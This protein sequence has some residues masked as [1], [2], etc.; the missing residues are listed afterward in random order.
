M[1]I[2]L[3][4]A[5]VAKTPYPVYPLGISMIAA[6]LRNDGHDVVMFDFLQHDMS[7]ATLTAAIRETSPEL[8]GISLRNIDNVNLLNEQRYVDAV[9]NIVAAARKETDARIIIGGSGFSVMPGPILEEVG[10]D[11]G[12]VGEGERLICDFARDAAQGVYPEERILNAAPDLTGEDIPS[13]YYDPAILEFYLQAGNMAGVQTKR[14]CPH[15]CA[16]CTYPVLEGHAIRPRSPARVADD[17]ESLVN[18]LNTGYIFFTDSVFNDDA[19]HFRAIVEEMARRGIDTPWTA[20]FKPTGLDDDIVAAMKK[21]GLNAAEIGSDAPCDTTLRGLRKDFLF[22][23]IVA[24]NDL[25]RKHGIATAHYFMFGCPGETRDTVFESIENIKKLEK[26]AVFIFM[27]VRILPG[28]PLADVAIE[29]GVIETG[30]DLLEPVYYISPDIDRDWL[31][32]TL[33]DA[34]AGIRHCVFPPDALESSLSFLHK[35]G[36]SGSMFDMLA[37]PRSRGRSRSGEDTQPCRDTGR[38]DPPGRPQE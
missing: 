17:I 12:I 8:I 20:F 22:D 18:E 25:F 38:A 10:A 15:R 29:Q 4:A 37:N 3:I 2:L 21:T 36:Y 34:F 1:R 16:Y 24:C 23:D 31:E 27:G 6:A 30:R 7:I 28:T 35:M 33:T 5:N 19:G 13:A 11:Y 14:G 9:K 32:R 26:A